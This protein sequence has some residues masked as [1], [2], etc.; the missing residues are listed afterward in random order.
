MDIL[1][2]EEKIERNKV[3]AFIIVQIKKGPFFFYILHETYEIRRV[4]EIKSGMSFSLV[5]LM[6]IL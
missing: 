3:S 1:T 4:S 2:G 6:K 5:P